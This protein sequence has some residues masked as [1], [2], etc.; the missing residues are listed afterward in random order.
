[1]MAPNF[2]AAKWRKGPGSGDGG[3]VEVAYSEGWI[4]VRDTKDKGTGPILTFNE[5]EWRAFVEGAQDGVFN[6]ETLSD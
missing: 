5:T 4:G 1:M 6:Y 3:C 2:S